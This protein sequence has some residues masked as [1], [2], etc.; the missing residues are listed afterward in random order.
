V[1]AETDYTWMRVVLR[2]LYQ[3]W[4][5]EQALAA[6]RNR[7]QLAALRAEMDARVRETGAANAIPAGEFGDNLLLALL[8]LRAKFAETDGM[9][10]LETN[11]AMRRR[12]TGAR[13]GS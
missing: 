13:F 9:A 1:S 5:V 10:K 4:T 3:D 8:T 2:S 12:G 11:I 6:I 7:E